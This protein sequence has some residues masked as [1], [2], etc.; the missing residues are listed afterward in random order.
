VLFSYEYDKI[1][2][3]TVLKVVGFILAHGFRVFFVNGKTSLWQKQVVEEA[4][5]LMTAKKER[6]GRERETERERER[7]RD[8]TISFLSLFCLIWD[9]IVLNSLA[10]IHCETF[11]LSCL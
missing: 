6:K 5:Y 1:P 2:E 7:E 9:P 8:Y 11:P 10:H 4:S 3:K